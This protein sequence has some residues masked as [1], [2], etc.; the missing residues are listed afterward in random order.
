MRLLSIDV[1]SDF[2]GK[3]I[4]LVTMRKGEMTVI[5]PKGDLIHL[6]FDIPARGIIGL[7]NNMLT[8]TS[9][10]AVM[11]HRFRAYDKFKGDDL[12]P[13]RMVHWSHLMKEWQQDT[14]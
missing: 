8:A 4:E 13:L 2:S 12:L 11:Y 7:R 9:G 14:L 10:E 5:E 3:V 1:P 6:E